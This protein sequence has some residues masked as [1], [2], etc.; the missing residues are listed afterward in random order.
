LNIF[1]EERIIEKISQEY[2]IPKENDLVTIIK[3]LYENK[4]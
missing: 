1:I 2:G 4:S 3:K